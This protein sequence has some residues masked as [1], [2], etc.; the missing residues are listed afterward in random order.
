[1]AFNCN[2]H[3]RHENVATFI[4]RTE[5][6]GPGGNGD[7]ING[8]AALQNAC[9]FTV[10]TLRALLGQSTSSKSIPLSRI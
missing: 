2:V 5:Y 6:M 10:P 7:T 1:M 4:V 8:W 9:F 3:L